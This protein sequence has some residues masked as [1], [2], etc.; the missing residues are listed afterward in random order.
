MSRR[1][2]RTPA[3]NNLSAFR[4]LHT[5]ICLSE[6]DRRSTES[7]AHNNQSIIGEHWA[8]WAAEAHSWIFF[9][10]P[11][12]HRIKWNTGI[13]Y[14]SASTWRGS[15]TL[16]QGEAMWL[17]TGAAREGSLLGTWDQME[18]EEEEE[19]ACWP[20]VTTTQ[21]LS[22]WTRPRREP[23]VPSPHHKLENIHLYS[24]PVPCAVGPS[25]ANLDPPDPYRF[26]LDPDP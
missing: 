3:N 14:R 7:L 25:V 16:L 10:D 19:L 20:P 1:S 17:S 21:A 22:T 8:Q 12:P 13:G 15:A 2:T 18:Y 5:I 4:H 11:V 24:I 9:A 26:C 23:P 6:V